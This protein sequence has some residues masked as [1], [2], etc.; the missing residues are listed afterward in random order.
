MIKLAILGL[1][2]CT[3]LFASVDKPNTITPL[4]N[5]VVTAATDLKDTLVGKRRTYI[6]KEIISYDEDQEFITASP[7][8]DYDFFTQQPFEMEEHIDFYRMKNQLSSKYQFV[9]IDF[10]GFYKSINRVTYGPNS[11]DLTKSSTISWDTTSMFIDLN[12]F[13]FPMTID[14]NEQINLSGDITEGG[15]MER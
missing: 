5:E 13:D 7:L 4:N 3:S 1:L 8:S 6:G 10:S 11:V 12:S 15:L 9:E 2:A 14:G